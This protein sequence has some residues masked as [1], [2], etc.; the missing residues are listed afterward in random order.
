MSGMPRHR[1]ALF[2]GGGVLHCLNKASIAAVS[3]LFLFLVLYDYEELLLVDPKTFY[4]HET[5]AFYRIYN[6]G[7]IKAWVF[8]KCLYWVK[9][10][11]GVM[12]S[13]KPH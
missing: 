11:G 2:L 12:A 8:M 10:Q 3:F 7:E 1:Y 9:A 6:V 13:L 4:H 5:L